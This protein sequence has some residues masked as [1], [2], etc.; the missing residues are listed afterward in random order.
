VAAAAAPGALVI[1]HHHRAFG[2]AGAR[3][4]ER[5]VIG[6]RDLGEKEN[7]PAQTRRG[8]ASLHVRG[9]WSAG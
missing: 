7:A 5:G 4:C 3:H 8:Q 6:G 2:F 9:E 1:R